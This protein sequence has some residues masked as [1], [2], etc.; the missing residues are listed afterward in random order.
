[1]KALMEARDNCYIMDNLT[2]QNVRGAIMGIDAAPTVEQVSGRLLFKVG[3]PGNQVVDDIHTHWLSYL[4][5]FGALTEAPYSHFQPAEGW[6]AVYTWE[7]L[8][9]H[10]PRFAS[11]F[12]KKATKPLLIVIVAPTTSEIGDDY[13][14]S[15]LHK[16]ACIK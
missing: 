4:Y 8:E 10:E 5:N 1:M 3:P 11:S 6:D 13:F 14:L 15:K 7:S 9:N 2:V 12:D 16:F